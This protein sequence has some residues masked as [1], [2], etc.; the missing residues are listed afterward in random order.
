M[1]NENKILTVVKSIGGIVISIGVGAI[2]KNLIKA[3]TPEDVTK[4]TKLCIKVGGGF[5]AG[6]GASAAIDNFD[7]TID[8]IVR[9]G[10][11]KFM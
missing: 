5:L 9:I 11:K 10:G 6:A 3:T 2:T 8:L 4:L 7:K 1:E